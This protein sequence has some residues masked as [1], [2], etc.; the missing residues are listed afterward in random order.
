MKFSSFC[1]AFLLLTGSA[2][3]QPRIQSS[4][5]KNQTKTIVKDT[6]STVKLRKFDEQAIEAYSKQKAFDYGEKITPTKSWWQRFVEWLA[7][8]FP[9]SKRASQTKQDGTI[10]KILIGVLA[11]VILFAIIKISKLDLLIFAK[12][13]KKLDLNEDETFEDIH[14]I[15]F[16][17]QIAIALQNQNYRLAVRLLYLETLKKLSDEGLI[18][19]TL[20]KTNQQYIAELD[21]VAQ[22]NT[23]AQLTLQFEYVWYGDFQIGRNQYEAINSN[24]VQFNQLLQ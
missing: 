11:A 12:K 3:A 18:D 2:F 15:Q 13:S 8:L 1:I 9:K 20:D 10:A 24:F 22:K 17:D 19:W 16:D 23:F 6:S 7:S 14:Q 5:V 21:D 4:A